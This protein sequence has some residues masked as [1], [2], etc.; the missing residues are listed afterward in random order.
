MRIGA[1]VICGFWSAAFLQK[2]GR[3]PGVWEGHQEVPSPLKKTAIHVGLLLVLFLDFV[4]EPRFLD[5]LPIFRGSLPTRAPFSLASLLRASDLLENKATRR[6]GPRL[7][8]F[9]TSAPC[10]WDWRRHHVT[11]SQHSE[12]TVPTDGPSTA[13]PAP[14]PSTTISRPR[15]SLFCGLCRWKRTSK[16]VFNVRRNNKYQ[17]ER[18]ASATQALAGGPRPK[19]RWITLLLAR[20]VAEAEAFYNGRELASLSFYTRHSWQVLG[21]RTQLPQLWQTFC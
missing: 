18:L 4:L 16:A 19:D 21:C 1:S 20:Q 17:C 6:S 9:D 7:L 3:F 2:L 15:S 8:T 5:S 14:A 11:N 13:R 10:C 12:V